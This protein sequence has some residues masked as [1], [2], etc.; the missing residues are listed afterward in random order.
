MQTLPGCHFKSNQV[1]WHKWLHLMHI[2]QG[3]TTRGPRAADFLTRWQ[4]AGCSPVCW[5]ARWGRKTQAVCITTWLGLRR[6]EVQ[7]NNILTFYGSLSSSTYGS[8]DRTW[9]TIISVQFCG[10]Q[11][12]NSNQMSTKLLTAFRL[13]LSLKTKSL[14]L[15]LGY[16]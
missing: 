6:T 15:N 11:Q 12:Q 2:S 13:N 3:C 8:W 9:R 16:W 7:Q 10:W 14:G 4:V 5:W 1:T